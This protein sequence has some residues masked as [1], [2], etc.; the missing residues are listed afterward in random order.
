MNHYTH[1]S[2]TKVD[3]VLP[4][5]GD[6]AVKVVEFLEPL[7]TMT[8]KANLTFLTYLLEM[9]LEESKQEVERQKLQSHSQT[10]VD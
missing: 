4:S 9:A 10:S 2:K 7:S 1:L 6:V 3:T 5:K 8:N